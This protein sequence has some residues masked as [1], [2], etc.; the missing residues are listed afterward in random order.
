M[1]S[2]MS[3]RLAGRRIDLSG[4]QYKR[5]NS[6]RLEDIDNY[7]R[8]EDISC[9]THRQGMSEGRFAKRVV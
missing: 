7:L 2:E 8:H 1:V 6:R 4:I 5:R 3:F 9:R